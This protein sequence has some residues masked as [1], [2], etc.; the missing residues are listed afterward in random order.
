MADEIELKDDE[1]RIH[2]ANLS[3]LDKKFEKMAKV[4]KEVGTKPPSYKIVREEFKEDREFDEAIGQWVSKGFHKNLVITVEGEAPKLAGWTFIASITHTKD[5]NL[6][7]KVPGIEE[8]VPEQYREGAPWCDYCQTRRRRTDSF[9]VRSESGEYKQIGRNCL[10]KFL[11]YSNPERVAR[12]AQ[13]LA[14]LRYEISDQEEK[15]FASGGRR[16]EYRDLESFLTMV[17]AVV[18]NQGWRSITSARET[19]R[20]ATIQEVEHQLS[21]YT[22]WHQKPNYESPIKPTEEQHER[23]LAAIKFARSDKLTTDSDFKHNLKLSTASD[24]F[25]EKASGI[26]A[27]LINFHERDREWEL[28]RAQWKQEADE[29]KAKE[30]QSNY[31]GEV[32]ERITLPVQVVRRKQLEGQFGITYMFRMLDGD[33]D[34]LVWFASNDALDEGKWYNITGTVKKLETYDGV[35]QTIITRCKAEEIESVVVEGEDVGNPFGDETA[36]SHKTVK[37]KVVRARRGRQPQPTSV[38]GIRR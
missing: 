6:I 4:A 7:N 34:V 16:S 2:E 22:K 17:V 35:K 5:G 27:S 13:W 33:G 12:F 19:G 15:L 11:G 20:P 18:D 37:R 36:Q 26:V 9:I 1:Y 32:G 10:A 3:W 23:A 31:V 38:G 29:R 14:E 24:M 8:N 28:R 30:K 21:P 25:H